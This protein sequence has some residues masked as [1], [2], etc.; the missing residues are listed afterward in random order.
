MGSWGREDTW[1]GGVWWPGQSRWWQLDWVVPHLVSQK[2]QLWRETDHATQGSSRW[3]E[4]L[5]TSGCKNMWGLWQ[6]EKLPV[7]Q[8]SLLEVPMG[9]QNIYK[10]THQ[11]ISTRAAPGRAQFTCGKQGKWLKA[12]ESWAGGIVPFLTPP[13]HTAKKVA[14][15]WWIPKAP[16]LTM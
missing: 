4:S 7:S 3:K 12:G 1:Q 11:G 14:P 15:P 6:Q 16:P 5:K 9:S 8:E 2:E 10:S 13:L